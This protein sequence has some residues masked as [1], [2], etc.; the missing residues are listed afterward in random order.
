[1]S[2]V[3]PGGI[4]SISIAQSMATSQRSD[5]PEAKADANAQ[6]LA[7]DQR[8]AA[9][10]GTGDVADVDLSADRDADGRMPWQVATPTE[11]P[12]EE[13]AE[14]STSASLRKPLPPDPHGKLGQSLDLE[15]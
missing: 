11:K 5:G 15:V 8:S 10:G 6:A 4:P 7:F 3:G 13:T 9:M 2:T 14:N 1:M 12:E